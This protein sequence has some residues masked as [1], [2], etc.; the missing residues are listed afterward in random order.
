MTKLGS[1]LA[2]GGDGKSLRHKYEEIYQKSD[3]WLYAKSHGVDSV[4]LG[5]IRKEIQN[6]RV[7]DLDCGAGR[8][9][10]MC[11]HSAAHVDAVDFS[12]SAIFIAERNGECCGV[13]NIQFHVADVDSFEPPTE[14]M[15]DVITST[16]VLEHAPNPLN[17]LKRLNAML[18]P[19]G[20]AVVSCPN[21]LNFRGHTYMTLLTLWGLPMS[22]ADRRQVDY[23]DI[24]DWSEKSGFVHEGTVG[25]IYDFGW[26]K[27]AV[28]DMIKRVPA[29]IED[30]PVPLELDYDA[31]GKW[32][33]KCLDSNL[34]YLEYLEHAGI[35]K[36]IQRQIE[37]RFHRKADVPDG[38]WEKMNQYITEDIATDPY[39]CEEEPHCY[40]GGEAIYFLRK[41]G[42]ER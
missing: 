39:Y 1:F 22:L 42:P 15:Y 23:Q 27:K 11:A 41:K 10:I 40:F 24:R 13:S 6:K 35:L 9:A 31:Y 32:L 3:V 7:L 25:A 19:G 38:L 2:E 12:E 26:G 30:K 17:T 33:Q 8:L 28:A 14:E 34:R 21:F 29:A 4:V 16:G 18:V 20:L 37:L 36:R 5:Q